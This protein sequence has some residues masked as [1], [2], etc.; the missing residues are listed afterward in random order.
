MLH[1]LSL[2]VTGLLAS[3]AFGADP[4]SPVQGPKLTDLQQARNMAMGGAFES[5]GYGAEVISGNPAGLTMYKRYQIEANG[6]WDI[7][8]GYATGG[9]S[10]ADSS[11]SALGMGISYNFVTF[12][13][14]NRRWA[15]LTTVALAYAV[16]DWLHLGVSGRHQVI[17]GFTNTNSITMS[18]GLILRPFDWLSMG[19]SGHNLIPN[20]NSDV[21]RYFVASVSSVIAGQLSPVFDLRIDFNRPTPR[22]AYMAGVE[23]LILQRVPLRVGYQQDN[24]GI[25]DLNHHTYLSGGLGWFVEGSG[26]DVSYRHEL[27]GDAGRLIA[28]TA[29]LQL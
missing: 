9:V 8:S 4:T 21:T 22:F 13:A 5:L 27:G 14:F 29:K 7:P 19:F 12:G 3:S 26:V 24:I 6:A 11:S 16:A 1:R 15:H 10:L 2:L 28:L 23:W 25:D 20:Y 17:T 18:A